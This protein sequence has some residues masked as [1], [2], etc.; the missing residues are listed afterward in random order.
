MK[1]A[2]T[3]LLGLI[4]LA[5]VAASCGCRTMSPSQREAWLWENQHEW[6]IQADYNR[7]IMLWSR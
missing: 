3:I 1:H 4:L 7:A 6:D 2:C 5:I